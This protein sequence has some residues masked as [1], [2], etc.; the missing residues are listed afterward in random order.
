MV[1][2]ACALRFGN[3]LRLRPLRI[4]RPHPNR[5]LKEIAVGW[6]ARSGAWNLTHEEAGW[7][8][9]EWPGG[10]LLLGQKR[11]LAQN[12]S[13]GR[14]DGQA[15]SGIVIHVERP[16]RVVPEWADAS[17]LLGAVAEP[18]QGPE[19]CAGLTVE[20]A[21]F[22]CPA[23]RDPEPSVGMQAHRADQPK[24]LRA[25]LLRAD[26]KL[27]RENER[28]PARRLT[29]KVGVD[30]NL[31]AG[32]VGANRSIQPSRALTTAGQGHKYDHTAVD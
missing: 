23:I 17:L 4:D 5:V 13:G 6:A 8:D 26:R 14:I 12:R 32:A 24:Q 22:S 18:S 16:Q 11:T 25:G 27:R 28:T 2:E 10:E 30:H 7:A 29:H 3:Q 20:D 15:P 31:D 9:V 21:H 1:E 19:M